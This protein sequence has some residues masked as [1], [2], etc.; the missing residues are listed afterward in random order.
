MIAMGENGVPARI[1]AGRYGSCVTFAS[2]RESPRRDSRTSTPWKNGWTITT[3]E[4]KAKCR[5]LSESKIWYMN[6]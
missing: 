5:I 6:M 4:R 2:L 3:A 1:A